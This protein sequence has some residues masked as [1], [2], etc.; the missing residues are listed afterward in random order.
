M[1]S[2]SPP[3]LFSIKIPR[4]RKKKSRKECLASF[5]A[6]S[7]T[8]ACFARSGARERRWR[9]EEPI[10]SRERN[11]DGA[12]RGGCFGARWIFAPDLYQ[13]NRRFDRQLQHGRC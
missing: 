8:R 5:A 12:G 2:F 10:S 7:R 6:A 13:G 9:D 11:P 1:V 3:K 4:R